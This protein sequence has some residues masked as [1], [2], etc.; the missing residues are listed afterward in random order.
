MTSGI[1]DSVRE[2]KNAQK[3]LWVNLNQSDYLKDLSVGR[4][5]I[6]KMFEIIYL[7]RVDWILLAKD[8]NQRSG[9]LL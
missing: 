4:R 1:C 7:K 3:Y 2:K 8:G 5:I 9:V 6:L